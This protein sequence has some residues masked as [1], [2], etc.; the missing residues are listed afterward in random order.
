MEEKQKALLD[1]PILTFKTLEEESRQLEAKT[2][3]LG[4][5]FDKFKQIVK[6]YVESLDALTRQ[7]LCA[8]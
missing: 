2:I 7:I 1:S 8:I 5:L 3:A 6:H 4:V